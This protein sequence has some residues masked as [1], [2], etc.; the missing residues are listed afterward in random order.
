MRFPLRAIRSL[1]LSVCAFVSAPALAGG[2]AL[3]ALRYVP[4]EVDLVLVVDQAKMH[5][6]SEAGRAI[7]D[8]LRLLVGEEGLD[9]W[10]AFAGE[11][12]GESEKLFDGLFGRRTIIVGR[13][14]ID[15]EGDRE[16]EW[17]VIGF[18]DPSIARRL[19]KKLKAAPKRVLENRLVLGIEQ[20]RFLITIPKAGDRFLLAPATSTDLFADLARGLD[21]KPRAALSDERTFRILGEERIERDFVLGMRAPKGAWF[22]VAGNVRRGAL[23]ARLALTT[24]EPMPEARP[25][26]SD[27]VGEF[28]SDSL[29]CVVERIP[30]RTV[31]EEAWKAMMPRL[32]RAFVEDTRKIEA[33]GDRYLLQFTRAEGGG[34][35]ITIGCEARDLQKIAV[36]GDRFASDQLLAYSA[37][38]SV[39]AWDFDY[40]GAQPEAMRHQQLTEPDGRRFPYIGGEG[41]GLSWTYRHSK[42]LTDVGGWF[43]GGTEKVNVANVASVVRDEGGNAADGDWISVGK[44]RPNALLRAMESRDEMVDLLDVA[45]G[46]GEIAWR[47]K[48]VGPYEARGE[49]RLV[50]LDR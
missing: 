30:E 8:S 39:G 15:G 32:M 10:R 29:L 6:Q 27:F 23:E 7:E 47:L 17:A 14:L 35:S 11:L 49:A 38:L 34:V 5:R 24:R 45:R 37:L 18:A 4:D 36:L 33:L 1:A 48:R 3:D 20:G 25:W 50:V 9:H 44:I 16:P 13:G 31:G 46:V 40:G 43:V 26:S 42:A 41:F 2:D 12:D 21:R 19:P 28:G 22:G